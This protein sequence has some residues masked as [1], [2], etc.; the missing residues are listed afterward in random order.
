[1]SEPT[2]TFIVTS[3]QIIEVV[4]TWEITVPDN[5]DAEALAYEIAEE[6]GP[7]SNNHIPVEDIETEWSIKDISDID[8]PDQW[9]NEPGSPMYGV[10]PWKE[11]DQ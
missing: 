10:P 4:K 8:K 9:G 11:N 7:D 6:C 1:M 2:K 5:E 3:S